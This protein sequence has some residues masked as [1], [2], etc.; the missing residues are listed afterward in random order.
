MG[1]LGIFSNPPYEATKESHERAIRKC[2]IACNEALLSIR[3]FLRRK[4]VT[5]D[6]KE[7]LRELDKLCG[8]YESRVYMTSHLKAIP[9]M[10][11][12]YA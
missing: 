5:E 12:N 1:S 11:G 4:F 2:E 6:P 8:N 3:F 9:P 7:R 10:S